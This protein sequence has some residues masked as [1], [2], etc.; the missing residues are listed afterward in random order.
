MLSKERRK[1]AHLQAATRIVVDEN[2]IRMVMKLANTY[3]C[4]AVVIFKTNDYGWKE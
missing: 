4:S 2:Q 1:G 3:S